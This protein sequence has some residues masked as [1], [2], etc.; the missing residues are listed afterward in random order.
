MSNVQVERQLAL[1]HRGARDLFEV[2]AA[3]LKDCVSVFDDLAAQ[4]N[5]RL[6]RDEAVTPRDI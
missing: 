5:R 4:A 3:W 2:S 6:F 1:E